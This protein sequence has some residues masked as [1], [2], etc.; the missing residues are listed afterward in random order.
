MAVKCGG[1]ELLQKV[2]EW[3][4]E[5]LTSEELNNILLLAT[6]DEGRNVFHMAAKCGRIEVLQKVCK[7][8]KDKVTTEGI[9]K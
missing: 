5:K 8:A 1:L 9:S 6:D 2:W 7:W 4:N 3:A